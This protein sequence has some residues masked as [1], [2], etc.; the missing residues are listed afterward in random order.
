[1]DPLDDL[2]LDRL[3]RHWEAPPAP[4]TLRQ[5]VFPR[6]MPA[7]RWLLTGTIRIPVPV[8]AAALVLAA[9]WIYTAV[10]PSRASV[11]PGSTVVSLADFQP[12]AALEPR[13]VGKIV[14]ESR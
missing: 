5:R 11:E 2:E 6:R 14:G 10:A 8:G 9:V 3:L 4:A 13:I 7:W 12:V 1:M